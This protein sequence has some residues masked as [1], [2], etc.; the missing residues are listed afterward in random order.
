MTLKI[1]IRYIYMHD[2][3]LRAFEKDAGL[4]QLYDNLAWEKQPPFWSS[5][6]FGFSSAMLGVSGFETSANFVEEQKP[7][8]DVIGARLNAGYE[9]YDVYDLWQLIYI[10]TNILCYVIL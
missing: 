9:M 3:D 8:G 1:S 2:I 7:G 5:I 10:H 6:F 4:G